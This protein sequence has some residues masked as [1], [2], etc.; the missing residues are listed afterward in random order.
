MELKLGQ[1]DLLV[2]LWGPVREAM[3]PQ[4][5]LEDLG[6]GKWD[7][8]P[9]GRYL[10][11]SM[12]SGSDY[13]PG[14]L[15]PKSNYEYFCKRWKEGEGAWWGTAHGGYNTYAIVIDTQAVP[16]D[17]E[18]DLVDLL[19]KITNEYPLA[20]EALHSELEMEAQNA[21]WESWVKDDFQRALEKEFDQEFG[22]ELSD[23]AF[24]QRLYEL[25]HESFEA[26]NAEWINEDGDSMHVDIERIVHEISHN[27]DLAEMFR[28]L[29]AATHKRKAKLSPLERKTE[30]FR[31]KL[32]DLGARTR[33]YSGRAMYGKEC[34]GAVVE[35]PHEFERKLS[36]KAKAGMRKDA[37]GMDAIF[38]WPGLPWTGT[39]RP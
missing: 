36:A 13:T 14:G 28:R 3:Q 34:L 25:F 1:N 6:Y 37:M 15:V 27:G 17:V 2:D 29:L 33:A 31:Q 39:T 26:S 18:D 23:K 8:S 10:V 9:S 16:P 21:A 12:L 32:E 19:D 5:R 7:R 24:D 38:Y 22:T 11:P 20:D 35:Y 4:H 30:R